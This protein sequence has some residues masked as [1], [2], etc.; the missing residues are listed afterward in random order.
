MERLVSIFTWLIVL[1]SGQGALGYANPLPKSTYDIRHFGAVGDAKTVNTASVQAAIDSC[2]AHGG[3]VVLVAGG[4]Y[5]TGTIY[6]KSNITIRIEAGAALMGS[7]HIADYTT[8]TGRT[9]YKGEPYMDRCLLFANGIDNLSIEGL[10]VID[11]QGKMFPEK[12]DKQRN[13]PKMIR[14]INCSH[15]RLRD[16]TLKNP[17]SWTTE[18]RYCSDISVTG[19]SILSR[20]ISNGDGLDFDGCTN[21]R[22]NN[23]TF[24]TGDDAICLQTSLKDKP[25][26][27]VTISNCNFSSRWAGIRIGLLSRG[28]FNNVVVTN[29]TFKDHNDSGLKIQM[30]EGGEMTNMVFSNLVMQNVPRPVFFTFNRENA[31]VDA[32]GDPPPMNKVSNILFDNITVRNSIGG[33][34]CAFIITGMPGHP[35]EN[36]S[37]SDIRAVFP[38]GGTADDAK[39]KPA[40]YTKENLK[41]RWPEY[42]SLRTVVPSYGIYM[43]HVKNVSLINVRIKTASPDSRP[44]IIF[45][46][47]TD[48]KIIASPKP[49][50]R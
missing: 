41:G 15:I 34:N 3:G 22:V 29:C 47:V 6:L 8:N 45:N 39:N 36:I 32:K 24:N 23:S 49:V 44:P 30:M 27:N 1:V 48:D 20:N 40:E 10:G 11:G 38:G 37:F 21:V 19:I 16:I 26:Q 9:M 5:V 35:I 4:K 2:N 31:W 46:D 7:P 25:C 13:R 18:W 28:N 12:G 42:G 14:L 50:F 43:R 33:K 17:A